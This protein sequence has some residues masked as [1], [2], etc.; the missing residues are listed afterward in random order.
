MKEIRQA[1]WF[2]GGMPTMKQSPH[3]IFGGAV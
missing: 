2:D 3:S 1:E